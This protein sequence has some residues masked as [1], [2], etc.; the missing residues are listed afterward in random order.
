MSAPSDPA[1]ARPDVATGDAPLL[2]KQADDDV[3]VATLH[4]EFAGF[5]S[6]SDGVHVLHGAHA[7]R[8]GVFRSQREARAALLHAV[9]PAAVRGGAPR[10]R[11]RGRRSR[12]LRPPR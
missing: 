5:I 3:F 4:D 1:D 9:R 8:L 11:S 6:V 10:G 12:R 7:Q 2:W